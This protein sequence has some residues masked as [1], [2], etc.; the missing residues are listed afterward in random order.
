LTVIVLSN[1][2]SSRFSQTSRDLAAIA[3]GQPYDVPKPRRLLARD[4]VAE[5]RFVGTYAFPDGTLASVRRG[6]R[7]LEVA[8]PGQFTAGLLP[9]NA[10]T[11][12][13]PFFEGDVTFTADD[14]GH[15]VS[16]N[17]HYGGVDHV[18]RRT[19]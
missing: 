19:G 3:L 18:A 12:Y 15:V 6:A 8:V 9:E 17:A 14:A 7:F 16:L 1:V 10:T 13:A 4:S 2:N 11:F 5:N